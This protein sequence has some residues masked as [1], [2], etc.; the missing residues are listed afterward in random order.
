MKRYKQFFENSLQDFVRKN[1]NTRLAIQK[2]GRWGTY[3]WEISTEKGDYQ[4]INKIE[5][6]TQEEAL[7]QYY[8][9]YIK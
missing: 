6:D 9:K 3:H 5:T 4:K 7:I 2:K 1:I 8:N